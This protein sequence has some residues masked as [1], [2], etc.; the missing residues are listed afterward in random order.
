[1][2]RASPPCLP[3]P[4]SS[5]ASPALLRDLVTTFTGK[6]PAPSLP[7]AALAELLFTR[8]V[9]TKKLAS[10]FSRIAPL[11]TRSGRLAFHEAALATSFPSPESLLSLPHADVAATLALDLERTTKPSRRRAIRRLFALAVIAARHRNPSDRR[12]EVRGP[13]ALDTSISG[14]GTSAGARTG[15]IDR[16]TLRGITDTGAHVDAFLQLPYRIEISD[17][18]HEPAFRSALSALGFFSPGALPDDARSLAPYEHGDWRW[19]AVLGDATFERLCKAKL[20]VRTQSKHVATHEHR[21]H[22]AGY[23]V[24]EV[25]GEPELQYALAE[26]RAL[27]ARLVSAKDRLAW[28]LDERALAT[29]MMRDLGAKPAPVPLALAGVLDLGVVALASGKLRIVYAMAEPPAGWVEALR[30]AAGVAMTPVVLVPKRHAGD[31]KGMLEVELAVSEQLGAERVGRMLGKIA[32]ALGLEAEVDPWRLYDEEVVLDL[33]SQRMWT[34]GVEIT[35]PEKSWRYIEYLAKSDGRA[36]TTKELGTYVTRGDYPDASVRK[37]RVKMEEQMKRQLSAAGA[38]TSVAE[39][40]IA[41]EGRQGVRFG[42]S[43][44]VLGGKSDAYRATG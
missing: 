5:W 35:L 2:L 30:R 22:G 37:I 32:E 17:R 15:Y 4:S 41:S 8:G 43:V 20:L 13:D 16:T 23:V 14:T 12:V 24:R 27:G 19:R 39:R 21:M 40:L 6:P 44:R 3:T 25:P 29:A 36:V 28:R 18:A 7:H 10:L 31:A 33:A 11:S 38:D 42:V 9:P 26:D 34:E 1:V